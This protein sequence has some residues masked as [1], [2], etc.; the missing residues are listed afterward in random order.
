MILKDLIS[1][2]DDIKNNITYYTTDD[3]FI[4]GS[5]GKFTYN[6]FLHTDV[7]FIRDQLTSVRLQYNRIMNRFNILFWTSER[8]LLPIPED[9]NEYFQLNMLHDYGGITYENILEIIDF[10]DYM[11]IEHGWKINGR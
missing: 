1:Q 5:S 6:R 9:K 3:C 10:I 7:F 8:A 4:L 2:L 11:E